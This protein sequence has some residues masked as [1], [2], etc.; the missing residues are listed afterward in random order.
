MELPR[1]RVATR[2]RVVALASLVVALVV[3]VVALT[4]QTSY[5]V[6]AVF[7]NASQLVKGDRV[8]V[9][10]DPRGEA[11]PAS[12]AREGRG[13]GGMDTGGA[14]APRRR[15]PPGVARAAALAGEPNRH[16]EL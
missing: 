9:A 16:I 1:P 6:D 12:Q 13:K 7:T 2:A 15:G 5:H 8:P 11:K 3:A 10:G 4:A 14:R